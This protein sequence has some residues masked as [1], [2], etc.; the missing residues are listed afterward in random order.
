[1]IVALTVSG[2]LIYLSPPIGN[3]L[4]SLYQARMGHRACILLTNLIQLSSVS[5]VFFPIT[6]T[7]LCAC[8]ILMGLSTGFAC[9]LSV[10]YSG[11]VCEPKLRG[12]LTSVMN[13]F[14]FGGYFFASTAYAITNDWKMSLLITVIIPLANI[15]T[16]LPVSTY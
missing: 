8:S 3:L 13:V 15:V 16:L 2:S 11:E 4:L 1:M 10:S 14:Y 5:I 7:N 6:V 9:G 12:T